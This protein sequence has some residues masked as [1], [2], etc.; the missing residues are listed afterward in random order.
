MGEDWRDRV[1]KLL[2]QLGISMKDASKAAG[3]G[4]TWVRDILKRDR[5]PGIDGFTALARVLRTSVAYLLENR[6][7]GGPPIRI[8]G[9]VGA[10]LE[11]H[12]YGDG[13]NPNEETEAPPNRTTSTVAVQ[14]RGN[15]M[16]GYFDD[17]SVL[18][19][20]DIRTPPTE[21]LIGRLCVVELKDGRVLVK[22]LH[23]GSRKGR[24]TLLST[25]ADPLF[26]RTLT[27]A[28]RVIWIKPA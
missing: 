28:A 23:K 3:Q 2:D 8:I 20:D 19:Y 26:D 18:Y 10:G 15:S 25:N 9:Y 17:G 24:W 7:E 22:R 27:W 13:D 6:P 11:A 21:D 1:R 12:F 14:V 5:E 4:E 16:A